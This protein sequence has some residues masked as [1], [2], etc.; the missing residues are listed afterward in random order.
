MILCWITK[1][2]FITSPAD[3]LVRIPSS[4]TDTITVSDANCC[5]YETVFETASA[6]HRIFV[7]TEEKQ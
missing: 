7:W 6:T 4:R 1:L 5:I 3:L 2:C